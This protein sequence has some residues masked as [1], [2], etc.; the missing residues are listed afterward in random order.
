LLNDCN[1]LILLGQITE[2]ESIFTYASN[3]SVSTFS[4]PNHMPPF[5]DEINSRL[6]ENSALVEICQN[7]TQCL[8]DADQ[9][10]DVNVGMDTLQFEEQAK[11]QVVILGI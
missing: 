10:G 2:E 8:F 1:Q 9:T 3:E 6:E 4:H 5:M 7:N 11:E